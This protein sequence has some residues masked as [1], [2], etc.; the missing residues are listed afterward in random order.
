MYRVT[1][2]TTKKTY[3]HCLKCKYSKE[4]RQIA[5]GGVIIECTAPNRCITTEFNANDFYCIE[6][7][8][9]NDMSQ[10]EKDAIVR[11][12]NNNYAKS[13]F[14]E[15]ANKYYS[16]KQAKEMISLFNDKLKNKTNI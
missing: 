7:K 10:S 11:R 12:I 4:L 1:K 8:G 5:G 13:A 14:R 2:K 9:V 6:Y 3:Q 16:K 15:Y